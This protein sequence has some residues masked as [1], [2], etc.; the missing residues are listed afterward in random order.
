MELRRKERSLIARQHP[1]HSYS[2]AD[3]KMGV[4][5]VLGA[6]P[7]DADNEQWRGLMQM[8]DRYAP[9]RPT[10]PHGPRDVA[11]CCKALRKSAATAILEHQGRC[12][13]IAAACDAIQ[14]GPPPGEQLITVIRAV[15]GEAPVPPECR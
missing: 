5:F 7:C 3:G 11:A 10:S 1:G 14:A 8:Y 4:G 6:M 9:Q 15:P 2:L 13:A 12:L